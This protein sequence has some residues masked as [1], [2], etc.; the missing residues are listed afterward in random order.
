VCVCVCV[1]ACACVCG[2]VCV[3]ACVC[4]C[5]CVCSPICCSRDRVRP[6]KCE[7]ESKGASSDGLSEAGGKLL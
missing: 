4:V 1:C 7:S 6:L 5:V 2:C 3:C